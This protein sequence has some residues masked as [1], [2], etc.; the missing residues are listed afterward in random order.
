MKGQDFLIS[1]IANKLYVTLLWKGKR[2]PIELV[3]DVG[4]EGSK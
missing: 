1:L 3:N 4:K 2:T